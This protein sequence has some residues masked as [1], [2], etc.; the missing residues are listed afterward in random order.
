MTRVSIARI[1]VDADWLDPR[2]AESFRVRLQHELSALIENG[3]LPDRIANTMRVDAG[4]LPS[5]SPGELPRAVAE[6]VVRSL[7]GKS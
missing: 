6:R 5:S 1:V 4:E 2:D 3:E 7:G